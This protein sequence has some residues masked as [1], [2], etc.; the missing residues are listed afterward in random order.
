MR[1]A[2]SC[3]FLFV[4]VSW[5]FGHANANLTFKTGALGGCDCAEILSLIEQR[6]IEPRH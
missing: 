2:V 1:T 4:Y 6:K 5:S 3:L